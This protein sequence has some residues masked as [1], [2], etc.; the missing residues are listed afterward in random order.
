M[1]FDGSGVWACSSQV[2][3]KPVIPKPKLPTVKVD[4]LQ[5]L[6]WSAA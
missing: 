4:V 3:K 1:E 2:R 5:L 6:A